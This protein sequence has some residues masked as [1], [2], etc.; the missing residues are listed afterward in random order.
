M[1]NDFEVSFLGGDVWE[2]IEEIDVIALCSA[3]GRNA[4]NVL[5]YLAL[6]GT[7]TIGRFRIRATKPAVK[8]H[9]S[10]GTPKA[11]QAETLQLLEASQ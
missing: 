2:S 11:R 1:T 5:L 8:A 9:A 10:F 6:G 7:T 3:A 4:S